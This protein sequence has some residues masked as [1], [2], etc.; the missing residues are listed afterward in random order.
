[1]KLP[2]GLLIV[3]GVSGAGKTQVLVAIAIFYYSCGATIL[4]TGPS[5]SAIDNAAALFA[6]WTATLGYKRALIRPYRAVLEDKR[7]RE[8]KPKDGQ[9]DG[10]AKI[11][12]TAEATLQAILLEMKKE[13]RNKN[14]GLEDLSMENSVVQFAQESIAQG[15]SLQGRYLTDEEKTIFRWKV[16]L[17][18]SIQPPPILCPCCLAMVSYLFLLILSSNQILTLFPGRRGRSP[19]ARGQSSSYKDRRKVVLQ[20]RVRS[21]RV[22]QDPRHKRHFKGLRSS[23]STPR[24]I[25]IRL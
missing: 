4:Y 19:R 12:A 5:N 8:G 20:Q 7:L 15:K 1:M 6:K 2:G 9:P 22:I 14:F 11:K 21:Q 16:S 25:Y 13:S 23:Q 17:K 18:L 3:Q 24:Y 10:T